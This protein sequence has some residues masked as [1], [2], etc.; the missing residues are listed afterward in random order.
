MYEN[1]DGLEEGEVEE[2]EESFYDLKASYK[3]QTT[4]KN[5]SETQ[6]IKKLKAKSDCGSYS[7]NPYKY[8][9]RKLFT[10]A[11]S[12]IIEQRALDNA[13]KF[14]GDEFWDNGDDKNVL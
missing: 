2:G 5:M 7:K 9:L 10:N 13:R 8:F 11:T 1:E 6:L 12:Y 14:W 3:E 4:S